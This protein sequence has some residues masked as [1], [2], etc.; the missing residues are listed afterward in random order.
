MAITPGFRVSKHK[1]H[2][3]KHIIAPGSGVPIGARPPVPTRAELQAVLDAARAAKDER[4]ALGKT[5][6]RVENA[7]KAT[8][9]M[10]KMARRVMVRRAGLL[11]VEYPWGGAAQVGEAA[12]R[13]S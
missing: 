12:A 13:A 7:A 3:V 11:G 10:L 8:E 9:D 2:L 4:R 1:R 6:A 5:V